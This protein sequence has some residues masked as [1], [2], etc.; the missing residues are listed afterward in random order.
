MIRISYHASLKIHSDSL[1]GMVNTTVEY[2]EGMKVKGIAESLDLNEV[3]LVLINGQLC[4]ESSTVNDGDC[5]EIHPFVG[6]G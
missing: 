4:R 2:S 1:I 3:G 6:G 5:I